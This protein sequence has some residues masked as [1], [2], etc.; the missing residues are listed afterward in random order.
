MMIRTVR[1]ILSAVSDLGLCLKQVFERPRSRYYHLRR[2]TIRFICRR[3]F[4]MPFSCC[5]ENLWFIFSPQADSHLIWSLGQSTQ[6][7]YAVELCC[8]NG[9]RRRK[10]LGD[11]QRSRP[12]PRRRSCPGRASRPRGRRRQRSPRK[13]APRQSKSQPS[14]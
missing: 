5:I 12:K 14:R 1:W 8:R 7:T 13:R 2:R 11:R 4:I 10:R 3:K 6:N 9:S